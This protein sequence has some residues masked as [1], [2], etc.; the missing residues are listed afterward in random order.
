MGPRFVG[1]TMLI[2]ASCSGAT[3]G[4]DDDGRDAGSDRRDAGPRDAATRD[5]AA[6]RDAA[7]PPVGPYNVI[8]IL[9]DDQRADA[10][11][12]MPKLQ[13]H[14]VQRGVTFSN[15]FAST[16]L[17]CPSR[18]TELTGLFAHNHGVRSN[19]DDEDGDGQ[20][21]PGERDF[22]QNDNEERVVARWLK[23]QGVRTG[24]FGKYLN[25]YEDYIAAAPSLDDTVPP[26]WDEWRAFQQPT[27]F[28]FQLVER[29]FDE[30]NAR[31]V[32]YLT[33]DIDDP[34]RA[35]CR[36][37]ADDVVRDGVEH[38]S[39]DTVAGHLDAF[40]RRAVADGV[41]FF[42]QYSPKAPH[43][44]AEAP[45]RY[46][47]DPARAEYTD[48]ALARLT[49]CDLW[50]RLD[51]PESVLE[52]DVSDKPQWVQALVGTETEQS[53][54]ERRKRQLASVL[55]VEDAIESLVATL[56]E[57]GIADRTV[58]LYTSDNGYAWGEHHWIKKNCAYEE[59][60]R[61][62]LV[63]VHPA[64][65]GGGSVNDAMLLNTD[66]APT[67][68]ELAGAAVPDGLNGASFAG[69]ADGSRVDWPRDEI[70]TECWGGDTQPGILSAIRTERWKWV[71]YW[72]DY[73]QTIPLLRPNGDEEVELY[74]L[75]RD[76]IELDNLARLS[77][78][79][80]EALGYEPAEVDGTM[81]DLRGR[82]ARLSA[83]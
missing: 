50:E 5:S 44:P 2:V 47:P 48:E 21:I 41:R 63:V 79:R 45:L 76:P 32:C 73:E 25:G 39:D 51:Q 64:L 12:C 10:I 37:T 46:Q 15:F 82:L 23:E 16:P 71:Q 78:A 56:D 54:D 52:E 1:W 75:E 9:A 22:R 18:S 11:A 24:F 58:I 7:S 33:P 42:A 83:E 72:E 34:S 28:N 35:G 31:L 60:S 70:L 61:V 68:A 36:D 57:L 55:A 74:D 14:L 77:N 53:L 80:L 3:T 38:H 69:L 13:E 17:C 66:L 59:C 27:F 29:G 81:E 65:A 8:L 19:D 43:L 40:V 4:G 67:I 49:D 6:D 30:A 26:Y 20:S 62:P